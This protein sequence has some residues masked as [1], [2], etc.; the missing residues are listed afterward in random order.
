MYRGILRKSVSVLLIVVLLLLPTTAA[1]AAG[2]APPV[3][4]N[5]LQFAFPEDRQ[6]VEEMRAR[7]EAYM[8]AI[9]KIEEHMYV[10]RD[11]LLHIDVT[12][13]VEIGVDEEIF[14]ELK[15]ALDVTNARITSGELR[16][17][18]VGLSNGKNIFGEPVPLVPANNFF[19]G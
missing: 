10:G 3:S 2:E 7:M 19:L 15:E 13:G 14:Q 11:K 5:S 18:T 4:E 16:L 17:H 8:E 9:R 1:L 6:H 12:S